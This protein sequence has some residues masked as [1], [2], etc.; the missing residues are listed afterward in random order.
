VGGE[1][2]SKELFEQL[3]NS[4]IP[5]PEHLHEIATIQK[6]QFF[7]NSALRIRIRDGK[8]QFRDPG[9][10]NPQPGINTPDRQHCSVRYPVPTLRN[11]GCQ[12]STTTTVLFPESSFSSVKTR[13]VRTISNASK[14]GA[15]A[16]SLLTSMRYCADTSGH[17]QVLTSLSMA[18][19]VRMDS[20]RVASK[21][22]VLWSLD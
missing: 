9:W 4:L 11:S 6:P 12:T 22:L 14:Q 3:V 20:A 16:R 10:K 21:S 7:V 1:H 17:W 8:I 18:S 19:I 15:D 2:S 5:Y 13:S